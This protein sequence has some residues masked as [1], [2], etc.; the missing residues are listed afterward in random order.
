MSV[1]PSPSAA[2]RAIAPPERIA[3]RRRPPARSAGLL[4]ALVA[5][6][7]L[8]VPR[9][10]GGGAGGAA[11]A[12]AEPTPIIEPLPQVEPVFLP[13]ALRVYKTSAPDPLDS[14]RVGHLTGL[15]NSGRQSCRPGAYALLD[16]PEGRVDAKALAVL[17]TDTR[18]PNLDLFVGEAVKVTGALYQSPAACRVFTPWLLEV[19]TIERIDLP[20]LQGDPSP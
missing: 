11:R 13:L 4:A 7:G 20:P 5:T 16:K 2:T 18:G 17:Y 19:E 3:D 15:S 12:Q 6:L 14:E 10:P 9:G 8:A 1:H